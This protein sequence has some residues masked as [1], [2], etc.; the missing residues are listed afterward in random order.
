MSR[1][2]HGCTVCAQGCM[3]AMRKAF[4]Q[5]HHNHESGSIDRSACRSFLMGCLVRCRGRNILVQVVEVVAG[6]CTYDGSISI[7][8]ATAAWTTLRRF[9]GKRQHVQSGPECVRQ[10]PDGPIRLRY[11]PGPGSGARGLGPG[12]GARGLGPGLGARGMGPGNRGPDPMPE[13]QARG[14]WPGLGGRDR[15]FRSWRRTFG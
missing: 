15:S 3:C 13:A 9:T 10:S 8:A 1:A 12:P 14:P 4:L 11:E 6:A 2:A 5:S 7:V